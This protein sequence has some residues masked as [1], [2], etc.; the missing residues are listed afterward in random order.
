[1]QMAACKVL[2]SVFVFGLTLAVTSDAQAGALD[3]EIEHYRSR[4]ITDIDHS[5]AGVTALRTCAAGGDAEG[6]KRA[7]SE[8]RVGWER[9]EVF[10]SGFVP[11]L[12]EKIDAW[13]NG[14]IG[15][16]AIEA[17]LFGAGKTD[18][19][20]EA[21]ELEN[22]L[23]EMRAKAKDMPLTAQ[24]LFNGTVRLIYEVGDSKADGG[25]SRISGTSLYDMRNNADGIDLAYETI[26]SEALAAQDRAL[27]AEIKQSLKE[28]KAMV[29]L[30]DLRRIDHDALRTATEE[31]VLK[32][33]KA[34][35]LL[36]LQQATLEASV[37]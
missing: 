14:T 33:Q 34:A 32:F 31:L 30:H 17:R 27:D 11:D 20:C 29:A 24:G 8:A 10:T 13:P 22:N 16:H 1:M 12:D 25:E 9:S 2:F 18:F 4:L 35:P 15:F 28:L 21:G 19:D 26:F 37:R 23:S 6:A 3:K 36:H 5:L 7:W